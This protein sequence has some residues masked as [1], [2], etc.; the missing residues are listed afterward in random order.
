[1]NFLRCLSL[2]AILLSSC[3][4]AK[5]VGYIKNSVDY[6][7]E[8]IDNHDVELAIQKAAQHFEQEFL[9]T[10][11]NFQSNKER[12]VFALSHIENKT[13]EDI[14]TEIIAR[15]LMREIRKSKNGKK[16][17]ITNAISW[18]S[19]KKD[20]AIDKVRNLREDGEFSQESIVKKG[21]LIA[22]N[23]SL[24]GK[25]HQ[26]I[27]KL[28]DNKKRIDYTFS[29]SVVDLK[30]GTL[31]WDFDYVISKIS[32]QDSKQIIVLQENKDLEL[33]ES[34]QK[35]EFSATSFDDDDDDIEAHLVMGMD[36]SI[37]ESHKV[38]HSI[39]N[40]NILST[41]K[42]GT[43]IDFEHISL[44]INA[45]LNVGG[46]QFSSKSKNAEVFIPEIKERKGKDNS[47]ITLIGTRIGGELNINFLKFLY[48]GGGALFD[49]DTSYTT[50]SNPYKEVEVQSQYPFLKAGV[51]INPRDLNFV[52]N[53]GAISLWNKQDY[54]G[55]FFNFA[56][57]I[58]I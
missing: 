58:K 50:S 52:L 11:K 12:K 30:E 2:I 37:F 3:V 57:M 45:L 54:A 28:P 25:I 22:P 10:N 39:E 17:D 47:T 44:N 14:D 36:L 5:S 1:M 34:Q 23:Y 32:D 56:V 40:A 29:W 19:G 4:C 41:L 9:N 7:S 20:V 53:V 24:S 15:Q 33:K 6:V 43:M 51:M 35:E 49:I 42:V 55:T 13:K 46:M 8:G 48:I 16:I 27:S 21:G 18:E 31:E 26:K 38:K